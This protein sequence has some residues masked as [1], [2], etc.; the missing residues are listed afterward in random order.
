MTGHHPEHHDAGAELLAA[1]ERYEQIEPGLGHALFE[2]VAE[3]IRAIDMFPDAWPPTAEAGESGKPVIRSK[4]TR[5][6]PFRVVYLVHEGEVVILAYMHE[7][8]RP[9]YWARRV[10]DMRGD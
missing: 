5:R 7:S 8:Q 6:F 1:A 10:A 2:Q 4:A 9:G 3:A